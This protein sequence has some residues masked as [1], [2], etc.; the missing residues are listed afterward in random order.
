MNPGAH[1]VFEVPDCSDALRNYDYT[2]LWE[3]HILYFSQ[4]TFKNTVI[5]SGFSIDCYDCYPNT[6]ENSLVI[7]AHLD[8][9]HIDESINSNALNEELSMGRSFANKFYDNSEKKTKFQ[10][11]ALNYSSFRNRFSFC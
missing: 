11:Q 7:V 2:T 10:L 5:K 8:E 4:E 9:R 6:F 1:V 3:E